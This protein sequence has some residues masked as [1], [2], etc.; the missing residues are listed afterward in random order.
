MRVTTTRFVLSMAACSAAVG[1]A[2]PSWGQWQTSFV[3]ETSQRLAMNPALQN[4][5]L[6]KDFAFGDFDQDGD[7][8]LICVRKFPGSIQGGF[9]DILLM[10]EGGVLTERTTEFGTASLTPGD[11]ALLAPVN[12]RDVEA[13]DINGDGWLDLVTVTT[14]SDQVSATLGQ[15][16]VYMNLGDDAQGNW[17]GF[18]FEDDRI[19]VL[20]SKSGATANPRACE[21]VVTDLTGDGFPDIWFADYDTPETSGTVCIDL[22]GDGDTSDSGE[23]QLSP[24]ETASKDYDNKFLV[25]WG[26]DP[27]GPGPGYFFDTT[28]TRFT[29]AQLASAFGN[30]VEAADM[31]GDGFKDVVRVN[32]LTGGQNVATLYGNPNNYGMVWSGPDQA[33]AGAPYNIAIGDLNNDG[34]LDLVVVDDGQDKFLINTGNGADTFANFT[35][36]TIADSLG[37][38]GNQA[39]IVDLDN[40]G[41][42][43]VL[44]ADVDADLPPFC[45][46]TGRRAHIYRNTGLAGAALLDEI[47]GIIP[48][49]SIGA[50]YDFAPMDINGDGWVDL[51]IGRCAGIDIWMNHPPI[52]FAFSYPNGKPVDVVPGEPKSFAV[53]ISAQGAGSLVNGSATLVWRI[54]GGAWNE[55]PLSGGPINFVATLPAISC[56]ETLDYYVEGTYSSNNLAY[57]DP[58]NAPISAFAALPVTGIEQLLA[59]EFEAGAEGFVVS[60]GLTNG[61]GAWI[62]ADPVGTVSGSVPVQPE[63]DFTA[64]PGKNCWVTGNGNPGGSAAAN[65]VDGGP[66]VLTSPT[67]AIPNESIVTLSYAAWVF[68]NDAAVPAEADFLKIEYS[69]DNGATWQLL[70]QIGTTSSQWQVFNDSFAVRGAAASARVR[71]SMADIG[72]NSTSDAGV[73]SF[74]VSVSVCDSKTPCPADLA[75]NGVVD[76]ADLSVLLSSW[77]NAGGAADLDGNGLVDAGDLTAILSS[78]GACP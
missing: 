55:S 70:R 16:R 29:T 14:M 34:K 31:N 9:P 20:L 3:Q 73:D 8:D 77:G 62:L 10:N 36:F 26:N 43:D 61:Q 15:P 41:K 24:A 19:P 76:A 1:M 68:C 6:E 11:Q 7:I 38:F 69:L 40:D 39:H 22:N 23:C 74:S 57:T 78:W 72:N 47:E 18:R 17:Q 33:I 66:T 54:D 59:T 75:A 44:I 30:A 2:A 58:S 12:D 21:A 32:T 13:V 28:N 64:D 48:N 56:G 71:F 37:E 5:N 63:N 52:G 25:N 53:T 60:G 45:P 27:N 50:T 46:S 67:Y 35:S 49:N 65:D 4:D 42:K 51:V